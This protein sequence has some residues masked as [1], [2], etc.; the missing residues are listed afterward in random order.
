MGAAFNGCSAKRCLCSNCKNSF[1]RGSPAAPRNKGAVFQGLLGLLRAKQNP[2]LLCVAGEMAFRGVKI[3][4]EN[5]EPELKCSFLLEFLPRELVAKLNRAEP[6]TLAERIQAALRVSLNRALSLESEAAVKQHF[7]RLREFFGLLKRYG[8]AELRKFLHVLQDKLAWEFSEF[9]EHLERRALGAEHLL[10]AVKFICSLTPFFDFEF[11]DYLEPFH[12]VLELLDWAAFDYLFPRSRECSANIRASSA[13]HAR[14]RLQR[15]LE[16]AELE[17][18]V[19]ALLNFL[20]IK[21]LERPKFIKLPPA[22]VDLLRP[23]CAWLRFLWHFQQALGPETQ[24]EP[25]AFV[26]G[27]LSDDF[28]F[29][30]C[31]LFFSKAKILS[32]PKFRPL[33]NLFQKQLPF[34]A[35]NFLHYRFLYSTERKV[36][37][38][39]FESSIEQR[40]NFQAHFNI[41]RLLQGGRLSSGL[42]LVVR[43]DSLIEDA[44][45]QLTRNSVAKNL[46]NPL[47]VQFRGEPGMDEG[48]LTKE[49]FNLLTQELFDPKF[50]MFTVKNES[51][52][53]LKQ[54]SMD[55][56]LNFELV[57]MLMGLAI[58]NKTLLDIRFPRALYKKLINDHN[59]R[60][61]VPLGRMELLGLDDLREVDPQLFSTLTNILKMELPPDNSVG[62]TFEITYE[63]WGISKGH[64]LIPDGHKVLVTDENK[65]LFVDKYL[66][67]YFNES[68]AK[69]YQPFAHGFFKVMGDSVLQIFSADDLQ[70]TIC[71][72]TE[73]DFDELRRGSRYQDG[74]SADSLTVRHFWKVLSEE[75]SESDKRHF[76]KFLTGNDRAPLRGLAEIKMTVSKWVAAAER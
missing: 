22:V 37:I 72:I 52:W 19:E 62:L 47:K 74:F 8:N 61:D 25:Q 4:E 20:T 53:W 51:F 63:S 65:G 71:G 48:G 16:K 39:H 64:N 30:N 41:M 49:F 18:M 60:S 40:F 10:L 24:L 59:A 68:I 5:A 3:E 73:L 36:E 56:N 76:L 46:K 43:R 38:L 34:G 54:D 29:K 23:V 7:A 32:K 13:S 45:V 57:G 33:H 69:Q 67:W 2:D 11:F 31:F 70:L 15:V 35:F 1:S 26:N 17:A 28:K 44:L 6:L 58:Y 14:L 55:C 66:D 75:F 21:L 12:K 50:G 42:D 27:F 9:F